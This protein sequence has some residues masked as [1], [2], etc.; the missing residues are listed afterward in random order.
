MPHNYFSFQGQ[1]M[2]ADN[3][4]ANSDPRL[5]GNVATLELSLN[6][7]TIDHYESQTG[8]RSLDLQMVK[9]LSAEISLTLEEWTP[10]NLAFA[11]WGSRADVTAGSVSGETVGGAS[12]STGVPYQ[13]DNMNVS[14]VV[15]TDSAG[16]PATLAEGTHY[17]LDARFGRITFLDLAG[18]T[19]PIQA[20]YSYAGRIDVALFTQPMKEYRLLFH[21]VDTLQGDR[22]VRVELYRTSFNPIQGL[23]LINEEIGQMEMSGALLADLSRPSTDALGQYG[24][25]QW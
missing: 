23:P 2:L 22:P 6:A 12:P 24:V 8:R 4:A 18:L 14:N 25:I 10:D 1:V 9:T 16:T 5:L 13:L 3:A 15:L 17:T 11:L 7:E 21:G 19:T 20:A